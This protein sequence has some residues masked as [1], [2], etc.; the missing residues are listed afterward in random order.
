MNQ[1]NP[2]NFRE[3]GFNLKTTLRAGLHN[4]IRDLT[5][6]IKNKFSH[7]EMPGRELRKLR[8]VLRL[9]LDQ[10]TALQDALLVS[11]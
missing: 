1:V 8:A 11:D 5:F 3:N 6:A 2:V 10:A 4:D 9:Q 7:Q